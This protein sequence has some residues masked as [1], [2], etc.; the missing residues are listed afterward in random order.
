MFYC[1]L[2]SNESVQWIK[3]DFSNADMSNVTN[4]NDMFNDFIFWDNT[5][6]TE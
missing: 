2:Q 1:A 5:E 6:I 3:I 4:M